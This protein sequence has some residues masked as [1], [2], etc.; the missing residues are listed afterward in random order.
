ITKV[1][2]S[3]LAIRAFNWP[4]AAVEEALSNAVYHKSY[5][6]HEPITVVITPERMEITSLPGPDWSISDENLRKRVLV[7]RRYRNRRIGDYLKELNIVEGR[8]TGVPT[9][10]E[11][12]QNNGSEPPSFE[13]DLERSYF[14]TVLPIHSAF[15]SDKQ[16]RQISIEADEQKKIRS[17]RNKKTDLRKLILDVLERQGNLSVNEI[18]SILGYKKGTDTFRMVVSELIESG[19]IVY[20]YPDKPRSRSQKLCLVKD[21]EE[22]IIHD[23]YPDRHKQ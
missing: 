13:T 12:M 15:T 23:T 5:Q 6:I 4:Y 21:K 17:I 7:S 8:N 9:I 11:A 16:G 22:L 3:E 14:V 1:P 18:A 20:L 2:D 19:H 10:L